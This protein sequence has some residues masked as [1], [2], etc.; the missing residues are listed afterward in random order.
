MD[1]RFLPCSWAVESWLSLVVLKQL[2][3]K[4]F[5]TIQWRSSKTKCHWCMVDWVKEVQQI[6]QQLQCTIDHYI[7]WS[8]MLNFPINFDFHFF[9]F[10]FWLSSIKVNISRSFCNLRLSSQK[11]NI[12]RSICNSKGQHISPALR[13]FSSK[14]STFP[15]DQPSC[16]PI[17][18]L[19]YW[20]INLLALQQ[21]SSPCRLLLINHPA[22][23]FA[24]TITFSYIFINL[25][26]KKERQNIR[27]QVGSGN[28]IFFWHDVW[29]GNRPLAVQF[30][31]LYRCQ[32]S[33]SKG[34][35]L[36]E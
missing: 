23:L 28:T 6:S 22:I 1:Q 21:C 32:R 18:I 24:L 2:L 35:G 31:D 33:A 19:D 15:I 9:F 36:Y 10:F 20:F 4:T 26:G 3:R 27:F 30:P 13:H 12:S 29:V 34:G 14:P 25:C 8:G 11:V 17:C 7:I 5:S 16:H